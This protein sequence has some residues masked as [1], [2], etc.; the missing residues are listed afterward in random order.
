MQILYV[1]HM[2]IIHL[3]EV[4]KNKYKVDK[5]KKRATIATRGPVAR[6][7]VVIMVYIRFGA[8]E[9]SILCRFRLWKDRINA[10]K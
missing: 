2:T 3:R 7:C 1:D 4:Q 8:A 5:Y 10:S 9:W 6:E